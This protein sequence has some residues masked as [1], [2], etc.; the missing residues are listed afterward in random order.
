MNLGYQMMLTD[1]FSKLLHITVFHKENLAVKKG[2]YLYT[3]TFVDRELVINLNTYTYWE[4]FV[5]KVSGGGL[6]N[7]TVIL[8]FYSPPK[9]GN[10]IL[11]EFIE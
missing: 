2:V 11:K 1:L 6:Q 10:D 4:G 8:N 9:P 5:I 7:S 3:D